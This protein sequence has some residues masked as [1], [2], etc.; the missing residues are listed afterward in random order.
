MVLYLVP[1]QLKPLSNSIFNLL[2][3]ELNPICHVLALLGAHHILH[4]SRVSVNYACF[5]D[6]QKLIRVE[7]ADIDKCARGVKYLVF[8]V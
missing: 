5:L 4:F 6:L 3:P 7:I 2:K 1:Q 8:F